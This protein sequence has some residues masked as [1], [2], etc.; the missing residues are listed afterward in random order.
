M[1][2]IITSFTLVNNIFAKIPEAEELGRDSII[3]K[4]IINKNKEFL[5]ND[6]IIEEEGPAIIAKRTTHEEQPALEAPLPQSQIDPEKNT[7]Q[8]ITTDEGSVLVGTQLSEE[9]LKNQPRNKVI[10]YLI[11]EGDTVSGIA[12]KFEIS[13]ATILWSNNLTYYSVIRPGKTLKIPP[14]TGILYT[15]KK[16]DTISSI[17]KKYSGDEDKILEQNKLTSAEQISIGQ[18]LMIP[19]GIKPA[20]KITTYKATR[21]IFAPPRTTTRAPS[22]GT[23]LLWPTSAKKITQYYWWRHA[24][25]DIAAKSGTPIY[26]AESGTVETAGWSNGGYGYYII[27]N[28]GNG[29]KTLYAHSNKLYVRK[30]EKVSRVQSIM[31]MGST[32]WSTGPHLHFEVRA[33]GYKKNP[34]SYIR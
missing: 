24:G 8:I 1:L 32:G 3:S 20:S 13:V 4:L 10:D 30:G 16:G 23:K 15:V 25:L 26:A 6:E 14:V 2:I 31:S 7:N 11:E 33:N 5:N 12:Q 28:H 19:D 22:S 34:L 27:I 17:A 29:I 18:N 9:S 21:S